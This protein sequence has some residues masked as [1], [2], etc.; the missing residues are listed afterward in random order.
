MIPKKKNIK[1]GM[2]I[3]INKTEKINFGINIYIHNYFMARPIP[4]IG[5]KG[6]II[7]SAMNYPEFGL[8]TIEDKEINQ[9]KLYIFS[10]YTGNEYPHGWTN[11]INYDGLK[12]LIITRR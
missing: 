6:V 11:K 9:K 7:Y 10:S 1:V 2:L 8:I 4:K 12:K 3:Y 5:F